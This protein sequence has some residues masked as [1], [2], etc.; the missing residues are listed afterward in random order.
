MPPKAS[1]PT[2]PRH[3]SSQLQTAIYSLWPLPKSANYQTARSF[4][5]QHWVEVIKKGLQQKKN[6]EKQD[7]QNFTQ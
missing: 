7:K 3:T 1:T 2:H 6:E 4:Q 5:T